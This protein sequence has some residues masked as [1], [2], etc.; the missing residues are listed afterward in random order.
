[1]RCS[2]VTV[3]APRASSPGAPHCPAH[4]LN[5]RPYMVTEEPGLPL[6]LPGQSQG[7]GW[8]HITALGPRRGTQP[9][10]VMTQ[11]DL[12]IPLFWSESGVFGNVLTWATPHPLGM[13]SGQP[14][15][16]L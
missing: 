12:S 7:S 8:A 4:M 16:C 13:P 2:G 1:M 6:T 9:A 3:P 5:T 10:S 11:K 14:S 15:D